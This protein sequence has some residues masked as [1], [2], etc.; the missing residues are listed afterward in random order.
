[1]TLSELAAGEG[2]SL[3]PSP[4]ETARFGLEVARLV[5]RRGAAAES[6][7]L[8]RDLR[9]CSA[10]LIVARY[11][12][13]EHWLPALLAG[14]GRDVLPAGALTYWSLPTERAPETASRPEVTVRS[15][16]DMEPAA[17]TALV[18]DLITDTFTSYG[19]HYAVNPLLDPGL[20]LEG[21]VEWA[22]SALGDADHVVLVMSVD[23]EPAAVATCALDGGDL[24]IL[25]A[26]VL[27]RFQG[28]GRYASLLAAV[29]ATARAEGRE[30]V[31][32]STQVHNAR[33]QRA[34]ARFGFE[35]IDAFETAHLLRRGLLPAAGISAVT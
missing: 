22:L 23:S 31:V 27:P 18:H 3:S 5:V 9:A 16:A 20:A 4:A 2:W 13:D 6:D 28:Q 34:W 24:E 1:V 12:A 30:R 10:D 8:T 29:A 17:A 25:L 7:R 19:N 33:V 15:A 35:P 14:V 11:P 32:I 21:Y 26:G